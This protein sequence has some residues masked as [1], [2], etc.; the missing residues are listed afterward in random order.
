MR[1]IRS[2][3]DGFLSPFGRVSAAAS[4][5]QTLVDTWSTSGAGFALVFEGTSPSIYVNDQ[6]DAELMVN[7]WSSDGQGFALVFEGESSIYSNEA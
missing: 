1:E 6:T 2:P 7:Q 3:L 5:A 4:A